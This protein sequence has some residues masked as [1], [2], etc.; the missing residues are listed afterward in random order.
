MYA[1]FQDI[2][3]PP[4]ENITFIHCIYVGQILTI[5]VLCLA[6]LILILIFAGLMPAKLM[7]L[8]FSIVAVFV[9]IWGLAAMSGL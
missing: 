5:V 4:I 7:L 3:D 6:K 1:S 2:V 8:T 9:M